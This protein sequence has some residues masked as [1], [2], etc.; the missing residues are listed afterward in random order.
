MITEISRNISLK[1]CKIAQN[2]ITQ[3]IILMYNRLSSYSHKKLLSPCANGSHSI[4]AETS[5]YE[6]HF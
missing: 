1:Y 2:K 4:T 6:C 5:E 3:H